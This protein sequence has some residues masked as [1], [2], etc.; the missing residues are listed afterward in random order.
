MAPDWA[1]LSE[2]WAG[3]EIGLVAEVDCTAEGKP[4]CEAEGVRGFPTLKWGDPSGLEDY[5]GG[6][7]YDDL[8]SFAKENLKPVCSPQNIDLCDDKKKKAIEGYLKLSVEEIEKRIQKEEEKLND[9][10][11]EFKKEVEKLQQAYQKL[12]D[13]KDKKIA[14]VKESG[15][16]L[17][18]AVKGYKA[19]ASAKNDEL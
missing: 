6:R 19:T 11:E 12:S 9:A 1:K 2:E 16:G 13:N 3:H 18:K 10:E 17:L 15:L 8:S 7:S 14:A 4:L 5:T